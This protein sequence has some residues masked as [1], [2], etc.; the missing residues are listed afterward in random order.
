MT[1]T[2]TRRFVAQFGEMEKIVVSPIN[3]AS[4]FRLSFKTFIQTKYHENSPTAEPHDKLLPPGDLVFP[5][6]IGEERERINIHSSSYQ[7]Q[8]LK[9]SIVFLS[10]ISR[11]TRGRFY[12]VLVQ[13]I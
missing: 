3:T 4:V 2:G 8:N 7:Y 12:H 1:I 9:S 6:E 10:E 5:E 11:P 13:Y